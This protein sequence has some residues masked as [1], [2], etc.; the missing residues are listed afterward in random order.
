MNPRPG[1]APSATVCILDVAGGLR[2]GSFDLVTANPPW[3][4]A[5]PFRPKAPTRVFADGGPTGFELP[6]RFALEAAA[7][8]APGGVAVVLAVDVHYRDGRRPLAAL[9]RGL[10]R[11]RFEVAVTPTDASSEWDHLEG[12]FLV[13]FEDVEAVEHVALLVHRPGD[14]GQSS[15]APPSPRVPR[16]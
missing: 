15:A 6:R 12:A 11:L 4:P 2:P 13:R 10:R 5:D 8:L 14:D 7:L 9:V 16:R 3:V 1:G